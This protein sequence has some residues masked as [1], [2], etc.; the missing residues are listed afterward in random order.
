MSIRR[1]SALF[2]FGALA[3]ASA[4]AGEAAGPTV[5]TAGDSTMANYGPNSAPMEGWCQRLGDF[6]KPGVKVD[7]RAAGGR[8]TLSF[9]NEGR[10]EKLVDSLKAGDFVIIQFG[11][12]DQ[13]DKEPERYAAADGAYSDNL[14]R[15]I[16]D[17]RAKG[18]SPVLATSINRR[19]FKDGQLQR[20]L[21]AYPDAMRKV[22][23]ETDT[24]LLDL[25]E[26]TYTLYSEAGPEGSKKYF[27]YGE[28]GQF[29]GH[30]KGIQDNS[31][32][33]ADGAKAVAGLAVKLAFDAK[34]PLAE[35]FAAQ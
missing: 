21:G 33:N 23:K 26:A 13:K 11:H 1:L 9:I 20:T 28:P 14:R 17:V 3:A 32:L 30:P 15:F 6:V 18:A 22:A 4:A 31:H 7:N 8:S 10:W 27:T 12:N 35:L 16:A 24:P 19:V 2:L 25:Y 34:M 5:Y 29:P